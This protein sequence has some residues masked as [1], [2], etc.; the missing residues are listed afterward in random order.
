[1]D[2]VGIQLCGAFA[3]TRAGAPAAVPGRKS[4]LLLTRL[5]A[6]GGN[7]VAIDELVAIL[8]AGAP[9]ARPADNVAT[10]VSRLR[11][12]LGTDVVHGGRD[13]YRLGP[14]PAVRVD[15]AEA[16][17]LAAEATRR[18]R[19]GDAGSACAAAS[20][21]AGLLGTGSVLVGE[22]DK[23]T[24]GWVP[25]VRDEVA[26]LLRTLRHLL[27]EAAPAAG[28]PVAG[29]AAARAAA[30]ADPLDERAH[31]LLMAAHRAAGEQDRALA[32]FE[33]LRRVL[34]DELGVDP[35]AETRALHL[36]IL[37]NEPPPLRGPAV[38]AP[39]RQAAPVGRDQE[40]ASLTAAWSVAA[41]GRGAAVLVAGEAGIGKTTLAEAAAAVASDTGG[42]V[43]R[44]RCYAAERSLFLQPVVDALTSALQTVPEAELRR[45]A[46]SGADAL[47]ALVPEA[48]A[49][50]GEPDPAHGD[51]ETGR[52][53][54]FEAVRGLLAGL[55]A[56]RPVLLLLDDLHNAGVATV[57]LLHYLLRRTAG[58]RLMVLATVRSEEGAAALA[59][60]AQ[61][62]GRLD[63]GPLPAD[64]VA[65]LAARAG[66]PRHAEDI[67]RRTRGHTLFVVET[68][69]ALSGGESGVPET[70]QAAVLSRL[71]QVGP[72]VERV[73][74]AG[75][76]LGAAVS[77]D[78][79][80]ALL[81]VPVPGVVERCEQAAAA[82]LLVPVGA[83]YEFAND[84]IQE[85][86]YATT[87]DPVR[88]A[89]HRR[90][91][92]LLA[93]RPEAA[94]GHADALGD[95]AAAARGWLRAGEA[96]RAGFAAAD[97]E[98]LLGRALAAAARS[99]EPEL[100]GHV[101]LA[102]ARVR[103]ALGIFEAGVADID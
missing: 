51:P 48:A 83:A 43:L 2:A 85:V 23:D 45:L 65:L 84:L 99:D 38:V 96:A 49:V 6:A 47:A 27:A 67:L 35:D 52:R 34:V 14:P 91:A 17:D 54:A 70:L 44:A 8:W 98:V 13:G 9:P 77:P 24:A 68:L 32:V 81:D 66:S 15:V 87:S 101:H 36:A 72:D 55:A 63:V 90:A 97:A 37:R 103:E 11:A 93:D 21:G 60:L 89:H 3:V 39:P 82:R 58:A 64:A 30:T 28:D 22:S 74:R 69:R 102:R 40:L 53:R 33:R 80:A 100:V 42:L 79:V 88:F 5:A 16:R 95:H 62:A 50:L 46:G 41:G 57:E 18:L 78:I 59:E 61:V 10:L 25:Q 86:L 19:A 29:V 75:A 31:R 4:R 76:V 73:L 71:R 12:A 94:A 56:D 92:D 7:V 1:M 26:V 20:R